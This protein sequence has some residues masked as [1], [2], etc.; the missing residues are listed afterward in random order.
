MKVELCP[1][2]MLLEYVENRLSG[3]FDAVIR[4]EQYLKHLPH[5]F[6]PSE[7]FAAR[8]QTMV[9]AALKRFISSTFGLR[10]FLFEVNGYT[11]RF[12]P[13][14]T[15]FWQG[16]EF[17]FSHRGAERLYE[18]ML[19]RVTNEEPLF[20]VALPADALLISV[21]HNDFSLY[22]FPWLAKNSANWLIKACHI[23]WQRVAPTQVDWQCFFNEPAS[24]ELPLREFLVERAADYLAAVNTLVKAQFPA[25]LYGHTPRPCRCLEVTLDQRQV[26]LPNVFAFVGNFVASVRKAVAYWAGE[27]CV[28]IDDEKFIA[29]AP[30]AYGL[31][32]EFE[33]FN[34]GVAGIVENM[35][36]QEQI[37]ESLIRN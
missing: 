16:L 20:P 3:K 9:S 8:W 18:Q 29:G 6:E 30:K 21:C 37:Y 25:A 2:D 12:S 22:S 1:E 19:R 33:A 31:D 36:E 32:L 28:C 27:G 23:A 4:H 10:G 24:V 26:S 5:D 15:D 13:A 11:K 14:D 34:K 35:N 7:E 17:R